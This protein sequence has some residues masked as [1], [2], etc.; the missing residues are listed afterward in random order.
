MS[1]Y[2]QKFAKKSSFWCHIRYS[3]LLFNSCLKKY[4][5]LSRKIQIS[6]EPLDQIQNIISPFWNLLF[7]RAFK[8]GKNQIIFKFQSWPTTLLKR[9]QFGMYQCYFGF[10]N[11]TNYFQTLVGLHWQCW[12]IPWKFC[13]IHTECL[14]KY[15]KSQSKSYSEN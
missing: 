6:S 12:V 11:R 3:S 1:V 15:S 7:K 9:N 13:L 14:E 8:W 2:S 4:I 10:K 5:F